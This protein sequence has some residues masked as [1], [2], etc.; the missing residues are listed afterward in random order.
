MNYEPQIRNYIKPVLG[1]VP[2]VLLL[3]GETS[4]RLE[5]FYTDLR[6]CRRR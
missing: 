1:E 6:R 3:L 2:L 4:S 5:P